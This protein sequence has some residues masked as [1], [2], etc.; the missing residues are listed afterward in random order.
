MIPAQREARILELLQE[1]G[2]V[3]IE[4]LAAGFAVSEMTVRRDLD[5]LEDKGLAERCHG[6]AVL[7]GR[8]VGEE[9]YQNKL[10]VH[11]EEKRRIAL[12]AVELIRDQDTLILDAGTTTRELLGLLPDR[13]RGL[14]LTTNDLAIALDASRAGITTYMAGGLIQSETGSAIGDGARA[15]FERLSVD[16]AFIGI[17]SISRD[18]FLCTTSPE[19]AAVKQTMMQAARKTV[20]LADAS[21]FGS[22]SF[23]KICPLTDFDAIVTNR[24]M[25]ASERTALAK[26]SVTL[27]EV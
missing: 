16:I 21:K 18:G 3:T 27:V 12:A 11:I 13:R 24:K 10:A 17:A 25:P 19:K 2:S 15:F 9:P 20:L 22:A 26:A 14:I 4:Q 1:Q 5:R 6:G 23:I 8:V 7:P